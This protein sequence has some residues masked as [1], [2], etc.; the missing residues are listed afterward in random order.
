MAFGFV[1]GYQ[2]DVRSWQVHYIG[3]EPGGIATQLWSMNLDQFIEDSWLLEDALRQARQW[4]K[5]MQAMRLDGASIDLM[6]GQLKS[7][8]DEKNAPA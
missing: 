7:M 5:L 6:E 8:V 2:V 1:I 3:G 4:A